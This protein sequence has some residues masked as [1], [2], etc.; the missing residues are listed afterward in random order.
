MH[1]ENFLFAMNGQTGR[2]VGDLPVD[3]KKYWTWFAGITAVMMA[4]F[5]M[6]WFLF[7]Q[8]ASMPIGAAAGLVLS[9]VTAFAVCSSFKNEMKTARLR[10][11]AQMYIAQ[12]GLTLTGKEDRFLR[13]TQTRQRVQ[14]S[15]SHGG[16]GPGN[17]PVHGPGPVSERASF[18]GPG[19]SSGRAPRGRRR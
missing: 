18:H 11:T 16:R 14:N 17:G 3:K 1:G 2:L 6:I 13:V 9:M 10:D 7:N 19:A 12:N 4:V 8:G 15:S 5:C